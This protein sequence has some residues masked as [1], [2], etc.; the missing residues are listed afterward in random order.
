MAHGGCDVRKRAV[1]SSRLKTGNNISY[2]EAVK[3]VQGQREMN[4]TPNQD[5]RA[6]AGLSEETDTALTVEELIPFMA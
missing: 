5:L 3:R 6:E 1:K 2:S 4:E